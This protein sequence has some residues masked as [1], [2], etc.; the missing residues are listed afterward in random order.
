MITLAAVVVEVEVVP[1]WGDVDLDGLGE[2]SQSGSVGRCDEVR[3]EA[4][5]R[6]AC[7]GTG[8]SAEVATVALA[9][10]EVT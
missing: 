9:R 1:Y 3:A 6:A 8:W 5:R 10:A 2:V 4:G 7:V